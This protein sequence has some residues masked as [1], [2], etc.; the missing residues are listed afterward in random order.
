MDNEK[1]YVKG[2]VTL[3]KTVLNSGISA[4]VLWSVKVSQR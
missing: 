3:K 2:E 4:D 1:R